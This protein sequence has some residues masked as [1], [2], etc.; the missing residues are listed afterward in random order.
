MPAS[1]TRVE[2]FEIMLMIAPQSEHCPTLCGTLAIIPNEAKLKNSLAYRKV[3]P[4]RHSYHSNLYIR[5]HFLQIKRYSRF[6]NGHRRRQINQ[7]QIPLWQIDLTLS[8]R[9]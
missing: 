5:H 3:A 6:S 1:F 4:Q 9:N 7:A 8:T 2:I